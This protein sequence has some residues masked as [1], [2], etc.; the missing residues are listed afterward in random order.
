MSRRSGSLAENGNAKRMQRQ[1]DNYRRRSR[2]PAGTKI[3]KQR[4]PEQDVRKLGGELEDEI[5]KS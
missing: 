3:R 4:Q 2:D 5:E 1:E